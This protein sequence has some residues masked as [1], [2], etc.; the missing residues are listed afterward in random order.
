MLKTTDGATFDLGRVLA[1]KPTVL[2]VFRGG[3]CPY[4]S[5]HL[6]ELAMQEPRLIELGVQ[7]IAISTDSPKK[8]RT[9]AEENKLNYRLLSDR[10]MV[11][12]ST[13]GVAYRVSGEMQRKYAEWQT[14]VPAV[15]AEPESVWLPVPA[16]FVIGRDGVVKFVYSDPDASVRISGPRLMDAV[17]AVLK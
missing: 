1:E 14:D 7:I 8:L 6:G 4:C 9:T 15:P 16:A 2:V 10:E 5:A 12:S 11:A 17:A 3:W 13:F